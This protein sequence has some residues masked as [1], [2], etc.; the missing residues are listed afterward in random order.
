[1]PRCIESTSTIAQGLPMATILFAA[2]MINY[3]CATVHVLPRTPPH[4]FLDLRLSSSKAM[5]IAHTIPPISAKPDFHPRRQLCSVAESLFLSC[6]R[7]FL[8]SPLRCTIN[9]VGRRVLYF[10]ID[11]LESVSAATITK[12][13]ESHTGC[14]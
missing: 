4:F 3:L 13:V 12:F 8:N 9:Q 11:D 14:M 10:A 1:M 7:N 6:H 5:P 2:S